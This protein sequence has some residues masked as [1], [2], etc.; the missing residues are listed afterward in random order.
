MMYPWHKNKYAHKNLIIFRLDEFT[1]AAYII[2]QYNKQILFLFIMWC[3][4]S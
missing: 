1:F 4:V 2:W 3:V